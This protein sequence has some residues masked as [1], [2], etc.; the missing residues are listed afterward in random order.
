MWNG[1]EI[2]FN[3]IADKVYNINCLKAKI[4]DM[5]GREIAYEYGPGTPAFILSGS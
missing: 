5:N 4:F 3:I 1:G 2:A